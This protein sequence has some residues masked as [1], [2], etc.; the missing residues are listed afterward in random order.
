[1]TS[2][3]RHHHL[4]KVTTNNSHHE[5]EARSFIFGA[6]ASGSSKP[7]SHRAGVGGA[8]GGGGQ[9]SG[10]WYSIRDKTDATAKRA[11][12]VQMPTRLVF[13]TLGIFLILPL[14]IFLYK[15]LHMKPSPLEHHGVRYTHHHHEQFPTWMEDAGA[16]AAASQTNKT[17]PSSSNATSSSDGEQQPAKKEDADTT[18]RTSNEAKDS[19]LSANFQ[20]ELREGAEETISD[21]DDKGMKQLFDSQDGNKVAQE[22]TA[23]IKASGD[24]AAAV[25]ATKKKSLEEEKGQDQDLVDEAAIEAGVV[26]AFKREDELFEDSNEK[27]ETGGTDLSADAGDDDDAEQKDENDDSGDETAE[28]LKSR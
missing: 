1:M 20:K 25:G 18:T 23:G 19:V 16:A 21:V 6:G 7:S 14:T 28:G 22:D 12:R 17:S 9:S 11:F 8:G 4:P 27:E 5:E 3:R 15:E 26:E 24:A 13:M 10:F 2:L